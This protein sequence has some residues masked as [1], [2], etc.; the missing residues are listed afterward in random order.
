MALSEKAKNV[1]SDVT[2]SSALG[3]IKKTAKAI[4]RDHDL[5]L[6]LWATGLQHARLLATLIFDTK[7][8]DQPFIAALAADLNEPTV[9]NRNQI[10]EW[11][12]ANQLTKSKRTRLLIESWEHHSSTVLQR[13][14]WY[15]Q[16]RLR[17][18][19]KGDPGNTAT[20]LAAAE[21]DLESAHPDVQ[22]AM[23]F[24]LGWIGIYEPEQRERC[25]KL[26][27]QLGLY[28][29]DVVAKNCTPSYLPEFIRIEVGKLAKSQRLVS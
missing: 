7:Q 23:N 3:E 24:C 11:L 2:E 1:L 5:A 6:E 20:L 13:L 25:I 19:G 22:W 14:F 28:R 9:E 16:A 8:L 18:T 17:W 26:G 27:E 12:L 21:K 10:S 4:K 15:H 29:D